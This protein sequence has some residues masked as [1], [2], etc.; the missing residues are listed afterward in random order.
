M[1]I[2]IVFLQIIG[3]ICIIYALRFFSVLPWIMLYKKSSFILFYFAFQLLNCVS[4]CLVCAPI[5]FLKDYAAFGLW[6]VLGLSVVS[7][8]VGAILLSFVWSGKIKKQISSAKVIALNKTA[9]SFV[10]IGVVMCVIGLFA[11]VISG[12]C[13]LYLANKHRF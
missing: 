5:L 1:G 6:I 9:S 3:L 11:P 2:I 4:L 13:M 10:I 7:L 12:V 8:V